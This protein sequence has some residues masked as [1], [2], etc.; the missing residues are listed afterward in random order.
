MA[1]LLTTLKFGEW[2]PD[3]PPFDNP[4]SPNV[5]NCLWINGAYGPALAFA[6]LGFA[7]GN[8]VQGAIACLDASGDT[9]VYIG[10]ATALKEWTGTGF[11]TLTSGFSLT[12]DGLLGV[13]AFLDGKFPGHPGGDGPERRHAVHERGRGRLRTVGGLAAEGAAHRGHRPVP[14]GRSHGGSGERPGA[15]S[16]VQWCGIGN[17]TYWGFQTLVDQQNQAGQQ[18]MDASF[19]A[20]THIS[21]GFQSGLIFQEQAITQAYYVGGDTIFNF[22][23]YERKRGT[24]YPNACAQIGNVVYFI[25]DD[26]FCQTDGSQVNAA[27]RARQGGFDFPGGGEPAVC[28]ERVR[29]AVD[30]INKLIYW[31]YCSSGNSTGIPDSVITYNYVEGKFTRI[32]D[33]SGAALSLIFSSRR[34]VFIV[35]NNYI[36]A[37]YAQ[38]ISGASVSLPT[39]PDL[40][41]LIKIGLGGYVVGRSAEKCVAAWKG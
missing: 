26:G 37:P 32:T 5:N 13:R 19:G 14:D 31:G 20:V 36:I 41:A 22:N 2:L 29:A 25:S 1:K 23:T 9:H 10:D 3:L 15:P 27:D 24:R 11:R 30:P 4:G 35:A 17:P 38:A 18:F 7:N 21:D 40:W 39:P 28:G 34:F 8:R 12:D 33:P 16:R 6:G